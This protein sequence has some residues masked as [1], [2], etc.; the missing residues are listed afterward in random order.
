MR[1]VSAEARD[2]EKGAVVRRSDRREHA[3]PDEPREEREDRMIFSETRKGERARERWA[4]RY[5]ESEGR[6]DDGE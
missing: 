6:D 4:R 5:Y 2:A 3:R 1:G